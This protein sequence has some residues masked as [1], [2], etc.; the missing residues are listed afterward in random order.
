MNYQERLF[1]QGVGYECNPMLFIAVA[2]LAVSAYSAGAQI[3]SQ[4]RAA[5]QQADYITAN[6]KQNVK[7]AQAQSEQVR[8]QQAQQN[9]STARD[10]QQNLIANRKAEDAAQVAA[11]QSGV[12]GNSIDVL[13][14]D[15]KM[16]EGV[17]K[18]SVLRQR[19]L[20]D[21]GAGMQIDT[22]RRNADAS[23]ISGSTPIAQPNYLAAGLQFG[24]QALGVARD[25]YKDRPSTTSTATK[26][27]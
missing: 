15:F 14:N 26:K 21:A 20:N 6:S 10:V 8:E 3:D 17:Y 5:N 1:R 13:L 23:S 2:S 16:Q 11:G 19:Q 9:E 27:T 25:Y 4:R 7:I 22:I 18:E 24:S 12:T